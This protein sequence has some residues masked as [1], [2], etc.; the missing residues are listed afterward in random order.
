MLRLCSRI[1]ITQSEGGKLSWEFDSLVSCSIQTDISTLTDTCELELPKKISWEG[2]KNK[3]GLPIK[4]GDKI[5]IKLGYDD[6]LK[7][8]FSGLI[9]TIDTKNPIKIKCE[10]GMYILKQKKPE[11]KAF[12]SAMLKEVMKHLLQG[13]DFVFKLIDE[14]LNIGNYRVSKSTVSEEDYRRSSRKNTC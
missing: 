13:T 9:K 5:T 8:R 4:K 6:E 14:E 12:K 11:P 7:L 2:N 1:T 10:D 3:N